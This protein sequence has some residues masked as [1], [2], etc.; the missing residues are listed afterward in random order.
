MIK[1]KRPKQKK[2]WRRRLLIAA[3]LSS[4]FYFLFPSQ[5]FHDP[6]S[7]ILLDSDGK[8]LSAKIAADGQWRFP[9]VDS[10]PE[11]LEQ[12]ILYF[13]DEYFH[14]HPGVNPVSLGRAFWQNLTSGRVKS[15]GSTITMQVI[16][17]S[18]KNPPRTYW[19]KLIEVYLAIRM[20]FSYSKDEILKLYVSHAP[21]G[22]NVVGVEAA[23]WRYF[24]RPLDQLSWAEVSTLAVLPNSPALIHP[25]RNRRALQTKRNLLLSKL[26]R[27]SVIDSTTYSLALMEPLSGAPNALP[28]HAFHLLDFAVASGMEGQRIT[29]TIDGQWQRQLSQK[30]NRYIK[31]LAE[32]DVHNACAMVVS[33]ETGAVEAYVGNAS[34]PE[35][36]SPF[37][38]IIHAPR[39]SG[40]ILK[41]FLYAAAVQEGMIHTNTLLR[42]VPTTIGKYTPQN[43]DRSYEG[44]V[45]AKEALA[46][47]LNIP[48]TLLLQ[49][50]GMPIFYDDLQLLGMS[51]IDRP[52]GNYGLTL[53]LGGAEVTLWD[54]VGAYADQGMAL[55][56]GTHMTTA[57]S[58]GLQ[59]WTGRRRFQGAQPIYDPAAWWLI[60][61]A[62]TDVQRP[63]LNKD[64]RRFSSSRKIAWKTGTSH[65]FRDAWAIGFDGSHLVAVWVGN[66]DGEGRPGLTGTSV[67]SP[68]MFEAF[69]MLPRG[70]WFHKPEG[71]LR[72]VDLCST[73]G[74]TPNPNCPVARSET[75]MNAGATAVC[76]VHKPILV[77]QNGQRVFRDCATGDVQDTVW[78]DLDPVAAYF[79]QRRHAAY[80]PM[81]RLSSDCQRSGEEQ[82][83]AIVYPTPGLEL[84]MPRDFDGE[85]EQVQFKAAHS[86]RGMTLYWHL[87]EQF[88]GTT[89]GS[90]QLTLDV[91]VGN[92]TLLVM[93][94]HGNQARCRFRVYRG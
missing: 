76:S 80:R 34:I 86:N 46:R 53:I 61:E 90:H 88:L 31:L 51:T 43:F 40:S 93:D 18:R 94:E 50:Y 33:L 17:M 62:L 4:L 25:G 38:D 87:D 24:N 73:T 71:F 82:S 36:R 16:R 1:V 30:V 27:K 74:L 9:E 75:S 54:L 89:T 59:L 48:A 81:P 57:D 2:H 85:F 78:F 58:G 3:I 72:N 63:G 10:V 32:N 77:G 39:S 66:A 14:G 8:L 47:S 13:E 5:L 29:T 84:I 42:D 44:V 49:K 35:A 22:G 83:V 91:G 11:N 68:L 56:R 67:A 15:G 69:Q 12:A 6:H 55:R 21:Y 26:V 28:T 65:G 23:S 60:S 37:V 79:Y 45:P 52:V 19:E 7:T 64:W 20:E 70:E 92:H 41:P